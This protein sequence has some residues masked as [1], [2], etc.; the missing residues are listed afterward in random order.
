MR[1]Q[2]FKQA[3]YSNHMV[4]LI[5]SGINLHEQVFRKDEIAQ[6]TSTSA[7]SV[8][9]KLTS[10]NLFQIEPMKPHDYLLIIQT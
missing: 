2:A 10:A 6:A 8:Y 4:F 3:F 7:I 9:E 1:K 5:Q